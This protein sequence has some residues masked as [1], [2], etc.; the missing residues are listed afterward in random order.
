ML[1]NPYSRSTDLDLGLQRTPAI[2]S[3]RFE[4]SASSRASILSNIKPPRI[5]LSMRMSVSLQCTSNRINLQAKL[6]DFFIKFTNQYQ[7]HYH[8]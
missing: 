3:P 8:T 5:Y 6:V 1:L 2:N 7:S 4:I